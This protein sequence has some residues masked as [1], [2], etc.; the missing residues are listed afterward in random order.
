M[1]LAKLA[2]HYLLLCC[3]LGVVATEHDIVTE[4]EEPE[5]R[6]GQEVIVLPN[7]G[8]MATRC[9]QVVVEHQRLMF[10][11]VLRLNLSVPAPY[12]VK[13]ACNESLF[14]AA[15]LQQMAKYMEL[16]PVLSVPSW[17]QASIITADGRY[18]DEANA[19]RLFLHRQSLDNQSTTAR[20]TTQAYANI[21]LTLKDILDES[22]CISCKDPR[23][24]HVTIRD[25]VWDRTY[26]RQR[27]E[28]QRNWT[29][30]EP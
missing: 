7:L 11:M 30:F 17:L 8:A 16:D 23:T 9:G 25:D 26:P 5:K 6:Y 13:K 10:N 24:T 3:L 14:S 4:A 28:W 12:Q 1:A 22:V 29:R 20:P 15:E 19:D 21:K 18:L 2:F 27:I